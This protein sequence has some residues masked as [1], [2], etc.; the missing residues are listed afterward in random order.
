MPPFEKIKQEAIAKRLATLTEQYITISNQLD[1]ELDASN[2]LVLRQKLE[3]V[4]AEIK[5][6]ETELD[7]I[8]LNEDKKTPR[9][10][11][12]KQSQKGGGNR[13]TRRRWKT[14]LRRL[15]FREVVEITEE[16]LLNRSENSAALFLISN[17]HLMGGPWCVE[18]IKELLELDTSDLNSYEIECVGR[19][20]S[21]MT[22]LQSLGVYLNIKNLPD[23]REQAAQKLIK[24]LRGSVR[25]GSV[26]IL[27]IHGWQFI[28]DFSEI[29][30]RF[31]RD[32]WIPLTKQLIELEGQFRK[33]RF[34]T[35][36]IANAPLHEDALPANL[37][38]TR[39]DFQPEKI[40]ELPLQ[41]WTLREIEEWLETYL[42]LSTEEITKLGEKLYNTSN[43]GLPLLV[44]DELARHLGN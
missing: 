43:S 18:R 32:F 3:G 22:I 19:Q 8:E 14:H 7:G 1:A 20:F 44:H 29:L 34:V 39:L 17:N 33:V 35:I 21:E 15:N 2:R 12:R 16:L 27:E 13:S 30:V 25:S 26:R 37:L 10:Q 28:H 11:T 5:Q 6:A 38:C 36:V 31:I 41:N 40:L 42:R 9:R 4:E 24:K 23:D